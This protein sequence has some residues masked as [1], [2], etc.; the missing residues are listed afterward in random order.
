MIAMFNILRKEYNENINEKNRNNSS[1]ITMINHTVHSSQSSY[2]EPGIKPV[3]L[4]YKPCI[5]IKYM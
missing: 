3:L 1:C 2:M 4:N 5:F